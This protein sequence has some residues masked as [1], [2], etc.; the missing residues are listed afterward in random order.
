MTAN[1]TRKPSWPSRARW[2][3]PPLRSFASWP[4]RPEQ[5]TL[6]R[7][8][9]PARYQKQCNRILYD[10]GCGVARAAFKVTGVLSS[11]AGAVIRAPE[12]AAKPDGWFAAGYVE[13][14]VERRM[15]LDHTG[16]TLTLRTAMPSLHVGVSLAAYAGCM[17]D[18]GTCNAKFNNGARFFGFE[19]IPTRNPFDGI[20]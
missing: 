14:G 15:I 10:P 3:A 18:S 6:K 9:P 4:A 20:G 5:Q 7:T 8:L 2:S 16:D 11:V 12:F 1:R 13:L 19:W 17:R